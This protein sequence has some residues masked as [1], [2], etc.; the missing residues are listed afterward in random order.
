MNYWSD[1]HKIMSLIDL[2]TTVK[3]LAME[4][5][6]KIFNGQPVIDLKMESI[7][8]NQKFVLECTDKSYYDDFCEGKLK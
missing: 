7:K 1:K 6:L 2:F 3:R 5:L 4:D 8:D